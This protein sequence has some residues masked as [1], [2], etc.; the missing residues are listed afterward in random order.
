MESVYKNVI[1]SD[2]STESPADILR[3]QLLLQLKSVMAVSRAWLDE[4]NPGCAEYRTAQQLS[5]L[6]G[7]LIKTN[8]TA[9]QAIVNVRSLLC[10][11]CRRLNASQGHCSGVS[12]ERCHLLQEHGAA[13]MHGLPGYD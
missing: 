7:D 13:P 2:H 6:A 11:N 3:D 12:L 4:S 10:A 5:Q 9:P 8:N 1:D